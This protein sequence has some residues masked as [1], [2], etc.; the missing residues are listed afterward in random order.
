[1]TVTASQIEPVDSFSTRIYV[2]AEEYMEKYAHDHYE[3]DQGL[4]IQMSPTTLSHFNLLEYLKYF[5]KT[6]FR[7]HSIG[8][9]VGD[10]FVMRLDVVP[11]RRQ[12]DIQIILKTNPG[13]LTETMMIGPADIVIEVVS[14]E[15]AERDYGKKFVEYEAGGVQE[16]WLF[17]TLRE[18]HH[19]YRLND[20]R[21]YVDHSVDEQGNYR[22]PLLPH[23]V[24]HVPTLWSD[25]LPEVDE[26]MDAVK[27]MLGL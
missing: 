18:T 4:L 7:F 26:I 23:F 1:M 5:L 20:V 17:D 19:F 25:T 14:E 11:S 27:T 12:P 16:Y 24:I 21:R 15:S 10:P 3:W 6:Y 8:T 22:T 2:S 9:Y 13:Q